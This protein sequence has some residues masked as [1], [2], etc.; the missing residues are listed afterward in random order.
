VVQSLSTGYIAGGFTTLLSLP[1]LY[2]LRRL[3]SPTGII[4]GEAGK[5]GVCAAQGLPVVATV[6][7]KARQA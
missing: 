6:D 2:A 4:V 7:T 5:S 3:D 1:V